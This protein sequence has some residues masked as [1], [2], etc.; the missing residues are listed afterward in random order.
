MAAMSS[1]ARPRVARTLVVWACF[2]CAGCIEPAWEDLPPAAVVRIPDP[3]PPVPQSE[4]SNLLEYYSTRAPIVPRESELW[5]LPFQSKRLAVVLLIIAAHDRLEDLSQVLTP[6]ATW[7]LPDPRRFGERPVFADDGGAEFFAALRRVA[8]RLP[9][10]T[11]WA[12]KP[13]ALGPQESVRAGAEPMWA[14]FGTGDRLYLR[15]ALY[16]GRA[17][18]DYVGFFPDGPPSEPLR[19]VDHGPPP[20]LAPDFV[21]PP[22]EPSP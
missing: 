20:P 8:Q 12:T 21:R 14:Y 7:G 10:G 22:T 4:A 6:D 17:R 15:M 2:S 9:A 11:D 1:L 13:M 16:R 3:I 18:I 19:V 5:E